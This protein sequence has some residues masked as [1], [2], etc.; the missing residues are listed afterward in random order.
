[1][2]RKVA[3]MFINGDLKE[4]QRAVMKTGEK[5]EL[6]LIGVGSYEQAV[7]QAGKLAEEGVVSLELCGGL[8]VVGPG[9]VVKYAHWAY[10][11]GIVRF[12]NHPGYDGLSGDEKWMQA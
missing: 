9:Q 1:M 12:D 4:A 2:K 11:V 3:F 6:I 5:G 8:G 10:T 7:E